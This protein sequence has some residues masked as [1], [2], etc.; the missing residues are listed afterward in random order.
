MALLKLPSKVAPQSRLLLKTKWQG[1]LTSK[2]AGK[3]EST[4]S[5]VEAEINE[6]QAAKPPNIERIEQLRADQLE[7]DRLH[8]LVNT[9]N[10]KTV[11]A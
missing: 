7:L 4:R 6:L 1:H 2:A 9:A 10:G 3:L 11:P 5:R 8:D